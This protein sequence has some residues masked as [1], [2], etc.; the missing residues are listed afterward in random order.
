M[1]NPLNHTLTRG[2]LRRAMW[3][4]LQNGAAKRF[5]CGEGWQ[6]RVALP[7]RRTPKASRQVWCACSLLPFLALIPVSR[8]S[9]DTAAGNPL[10]YAAGRGQF[11]PTGVSG[12]LGAQASRSRQFQ[13]PAP[14]PAA[15]TGG[16]GRVQCTGVRPARRALLPS[17]SPT[18]ATNFFG[19]CS[20]TAG[21]PARHGRRVGRSCVT[22]LN[23]QVRT[24]GPERP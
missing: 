8:S 1:D 20:M 10:T 12:K 19:G 17:A 23:S 3:S 2:N 4:A 11:F 6:K 24:P 5:R 15:K 14:C 22:A 18:T 9:A 7:F 13:P 16:A 21:R